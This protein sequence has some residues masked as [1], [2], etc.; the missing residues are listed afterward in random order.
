MKINSALMSLVDAYCEVWSEPDA[1]RRALRL[2]SVWELNARYTDPS[3]VDLDG[4]GL[5]SHIERVQKTRPGARV[6]R[7]TNIDYH[8]GV[9]RFGFRVV[10]TNGEILREGI[11]VV[12]F[13]DDSRRIQRVI[14]FFGSLNTIPDH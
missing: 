6:F 9:A 8:H 1:T 3:V 4:P 13:S 10:G 12:H 11:D 2:D 5:L 7:C 14:G